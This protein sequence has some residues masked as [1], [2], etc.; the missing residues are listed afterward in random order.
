MN[1]SENLE[2]AFP[3]SAVAATFAATFGGKSDRPPIGVEVA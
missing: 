1:L 2:V 3:E